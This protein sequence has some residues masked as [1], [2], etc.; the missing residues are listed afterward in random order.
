LLTKSSKSC[1][2]WFETNCP[3]TDC[4]EPILT[5]VGVLDIWDDCLGLALTPDENLELCELDSLDVVAVVF[6]AVSNW[7]VVEWYAVDW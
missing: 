7:G 3:F 1:K 4:L 5:S 2:I 6:V